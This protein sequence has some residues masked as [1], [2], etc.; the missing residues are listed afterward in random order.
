MKILFNIGTTVFV[1]ACLFGSAHA[2]PFDDMF[3]TPPGLAKK[4]DGKPPGQNKDKDKDK[5]P[6][7]ACVAKPEDNAGPKGRSVPQIVRVVVSP[8]GKVIKM[9]TSK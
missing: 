7:G 9:S 3:F 2:G 1:A 5:A 8:Q 6:A 4:P